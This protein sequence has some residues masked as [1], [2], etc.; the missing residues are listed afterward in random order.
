M[1]RGRPPKPSKASL[2]SLADQGNWELQGEA[3]GLVLPVWALIPSA[4]PS[5][6]AVSHHVRRVGSL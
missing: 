4:V 6:A 3:R 5:A 2:H 1:D